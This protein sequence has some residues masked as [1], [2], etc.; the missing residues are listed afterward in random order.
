VSDALDAALDGWD[1]PPVVITRTVGPGSCAAFADLLDQRVDVSAGTAIPPGW[2][3]LVF[4]RS[5]PQ[6]DLGED[7]HPAS[8]P[9]LPPL[10]NRRRMIAGGEVQL[11]APLRVGETYMRRS[12]LISARVT[13]GRSGRMLFTVVRHIVTGSDATP[14]LS[15]DE[16]VVYRQ[17]EAGTSRG[18]AARRTAGASWDTQFG[19]RG[20]LRFD[21]DSRALFRFSALTYN[22]HR[23]HYDHDYVRDVEDYPD[24]VVHGPLLAL[25]MVEV[26]RRAG[27][28]PSGLRYRLLAPAYSG[29]PVVATWD[30]DTLRVGTV[31]A[32]RPSAEATIATPSGRPL[33]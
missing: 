6:R 23:I 11:H 27:F 18:L 29:T 26:P 3:W 30:D 21:P 22:T 9:F 31:G 5:F 8:G 15:E 12:E 33:V 4:T 19:A 28:V 2:H 13:Q 17:Q 24:L 16:H 32:A 25:L 7:G 14:V 20:R 10:A 1:P